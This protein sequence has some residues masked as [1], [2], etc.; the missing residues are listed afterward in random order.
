MTRIWLLA[1]GSAILC[2]TARDAAGQGQVTTKSGV[3][4]QEQ[5]DRGRDV[6][7]A[8]C[9]SCH[10]PETHTG[11]AFNALWNG[12]RLSELFDYVSDKMPKGNPGSLSSEENADV[13]AYLLRMNLLPTGTK[14]LPADSVRLKSIT[15]DLPISKSP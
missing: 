9:K 4:S 7:L 6:Y 2:A 11:P 8:Y 12:K 15:I 10:S 1:A 3:Y 13:L 14:E 5:S